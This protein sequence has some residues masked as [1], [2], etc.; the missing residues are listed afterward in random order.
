MKPKELKDSKKSIRLKGYDYAQARAYFV[1]ICSYQ[2]QALFG[3]IVNEK[4]QHSEIGEI[5]Y[6]EWHSTPQMRKNVTLGEFVIMPNHIHGIIY[7]DIED[8]QLAKDDNF[9]VLDRN[10]VNLFAPPSNSLGAILR[11]F[12]ST[13]T[14]QVRQLYNDSTYEVWQVNYYEHIIKNEN[15]LAY[16]QNYIINNPLKW[17][18]DRFYLE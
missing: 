11:G 12:K 8:L 4:E 6:K 1:T 9:L 18:E 3:K 16:I 10:H 13:V 5:I 2:R 15:A 7:I 17:G 14:N